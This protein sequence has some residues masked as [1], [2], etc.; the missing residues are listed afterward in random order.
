MEKADLVGQTL[1][2]YK[3]VE[4]IGRG[5]MAIVYKAYEASLERDVAIKVLP[6]YLAANKTFVKRFRREARSAAKLRHPNILEIYRIGRAKGY[7]YMAMP[8]IEGETLKDKLERAKGPLE[9]SA[10]WSIF[11]PLANALCHAHGAG[12]V[13]RD[14]KPSNVL[15]SREGEVFLMDFGIARA[16]EETALTVTGTTTGTPA[17]MSPEQGQG[18]EIDKR[19]DI[20]SLGVVLYHMLTGRVPFHADTPYGTIYLHV[21]EPPL[22]PRDLNRRLPPGVESVVLKALAKDSEHRYQ[23]A[24]GMARDLERAIWMP[25]PL[26]LV[27]MLTRLA[28]DASDGLKRLIDDLRGGIRVRNL[29]PV[30]AGASIAVLVI[31]CV[32]TSAA[33]GPRMV[34]WLFPTATPTLT[35]TPTVTNTPTWTPT[36]TFTPTPSRTPT[37]TRTPTHTPTPTTTTPPPPTPVPCFSGEVTQMID[38]AHPFIHIGGAV[39][40]QYGNG[41]GGVL[42]RIT[43]AGSTWHWDARTWKNGGFDCDILIQPITWIVSLPEM[44]GEPAVNVPMQRGKEAIVF[45][46]ETSCQ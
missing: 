27:T 23:S 25:F 15:L 30:V 33:R 14:V 34:A 36:A 44:H 6:L 26:R 13:H 43:T 8:Y 4:E 5:G 35:V 38:T 45:F 42:V 18:L 24:A 28:R 9:F 41:M 31:V 3:V 16:M 17:Y 12:L 46:S 22:P 21:H 1:G 39:L 19:S 7:H 40:D 29:E 37:P 32:L 11:Q 2:R 20:Y 10:V